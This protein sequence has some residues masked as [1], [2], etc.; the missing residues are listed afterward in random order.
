MMTIFF[1]VY[2][3]DRTSYSFCQ[4]VASFFC[5][6]HFADV[7]KMIKHIFRKPCCFVYSIFKVSSLGNFS[8]FLRTCS[9]SLIAL[10][11]YQSAKSLFNITFWSLRRY[12][13]S[14]SIPSGTII[15][16]CCLAVAFLLEIKIYDVKTLMH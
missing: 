7:S 13:L 2:S 10:S 14:A 5:C 15:S 1:K 6:D 12:I 3:P 8:M 16:F 9:L 4:Y 11:P